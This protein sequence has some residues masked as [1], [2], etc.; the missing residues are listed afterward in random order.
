MLN[1]C[2]FISLIS[3]FQPPKRGSNRDKRHIYVNNIPGNTYSSEMLEKRGIKRFRIFPEG[4]EQI[5]LKAFF[6]YATPVKIPSQDKILIGQAKSKPIWFCLR[7]T[8]CHIFIV[9]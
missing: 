3:L 8:D 5:P 4:K 7:L 6:D 9:Y 1:F 2:L